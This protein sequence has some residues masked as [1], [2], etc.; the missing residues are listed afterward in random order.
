MKIAH[1]S[2][3]LPQSILALAQEQIDLALN[4]STHNG[5]GDGSTLKQYK[6]H[7]SC[8]VCGT[9]FSKKGTDEYYCR[10]HPE[11]RRSLH[12][13]IVEAR[14]MKFIQLAVASNDCVGV[15]TYSTTP[16]SGEKVAAQSSFYL[17]EL[18]DPSKGASVIVRLARYLLTK[19][20]INPDRVFRLIE[21]CNS[22]SKIVQLAPGADVTQAASAISAAVEAALRGQYLLSRSVK[23]QLIGKV[24]VSEDF[25]KSIPSNSGE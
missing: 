12:D 8:P 17:S 15:R 4:L 16:N 6:V 18:S 7:K 24:E 14:L 5:E 10:S 25:L 9:I 22:S 3:D 11:I 21:H 13:T 23:I 2:T 1:N 19:A 20:S